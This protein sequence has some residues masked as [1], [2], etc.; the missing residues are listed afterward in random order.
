ME[1]I[2]MICEEFQRRIN[3]ERQYWQR[4]RNDDLK[5]LKEL[6]KKIVDLEKKLK[7]KR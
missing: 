3:A 7:R 1:T 5:E 6:N 4:L 2:K